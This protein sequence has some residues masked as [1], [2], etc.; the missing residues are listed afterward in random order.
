M[1]KVIEKK[2]GLIAGYEPNKISFYIMLLQCG[3]AD[4]LL[5]V[6]WKDMQEYK[7]EEGND[8]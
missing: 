7:I 2:R 4:E 1:K 8:E 6:L 3:R 5:R